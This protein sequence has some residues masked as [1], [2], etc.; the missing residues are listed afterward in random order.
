MYLLIGCIED[1]QFQF[2][3]ALKK[4]SLQRENNR[5]EDRYKKEGFKTERRKMVAVREEKRWR[6]KNTRGR[7]KLGLSVKKKEKT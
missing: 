6:R 3:Y 4:F 2:K 7:K 1:E 5:D